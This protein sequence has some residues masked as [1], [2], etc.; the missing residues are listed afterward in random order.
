[1]WASACAPNNNR[2]APHT[3]VGQ[4]ACARPNQRP[5]TGRPKIGI[6]DLPGNFAASTAAASYAFVNPQRNSRL[7][8][9][10]NHSRAT[11]SPTSRSASSTTRFKT[12]G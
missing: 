4:R 10:P 12:V 1:M 6:E 8:D 7:A 5:Q 2:P 9:R 11:S 3:A